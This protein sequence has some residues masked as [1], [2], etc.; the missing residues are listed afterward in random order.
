MKTQIDITRPDVPINQDGS[1][2]TTK[3][4]QVEAIRKKCGEVK[5]IIS[6]HPKSDIFD[7]YLK[8]YQDDINRIVGKFRYS[9]H[10]LSHDEL[11]SEVNLS[12]IKKRDEILSNYQGDFNEVN[13][14]KLA[15]A[16]VRNVIKWTNYR[17]ARSPYVG[18]RVDLQHNT[19]DGFKSTYELAVETN[20]EE[21][22][23]FE[24][25]DRNEKYS[26][27]MKVVREYS[28]LF[29][30][31]E[32]KVLSFLEMG[33]T[34]HEIADKLGVTHQAISLMSIKVFDKI[35]SRFN[36]KVMEDDSFDKVS[37]GHK[38][39]SNFFNPEDKNTPLEESDR[40][41]LKSFLLSNAKRY[42]SKQISEIFMNGKY[43]HRQ[44]AAFCVKNKLAFC[45]VKDKYHYKFSKDEEAEILSLLKK[46]V[47][48]KEISAK[49]NIPKAS[50]IGKKAHLTRTGILIST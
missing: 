40:E 44:V 8:N 36:S 30:D 16:F 34:Q 32:I 35:K 26:Y 23:F 5:E 49:M 31:K 4:F 27:L 42:T 2:K 9:S 6:P 45:L 12:L 14:K 21:D 11:V 24:N 22:S 33:L 39:I 15:Y 50:V 1:I 7:S 10:L 13:F 46:G 17:V 47:S 19:E 41:S 43:S 29:S 38:A 20:G 18:K 48:S 3:D 37:E 28:S 25:H